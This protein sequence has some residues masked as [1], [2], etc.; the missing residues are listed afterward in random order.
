MG[1]SYT[2]VLA[3]PAHIDALPTIE[4]EAA[5][6]FRGLDFPMSVLTQT[7]TLADLYAA[8]SAGRLWVALSET[9]DPVGFALVELSGDRLHLEEIDVLT[10]HGRR[11]LGSALI[12]AIEQWGFANGFTA[13]TLTTFRDVPWNAPFYE[14]L[15]FEV[16]AS[17]DLDTELEQRRKDEAAQGLDPALR[18]VMRKSLTST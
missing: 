15:G 12:R 9:G 11:G 13:L 17:D 2:I 14:G 3:V 16:V 4:L 1:E 6:R 5:S 8:Q 10:A 7:S 18:I